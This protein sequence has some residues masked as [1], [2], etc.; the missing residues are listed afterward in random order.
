MENKV[1]V[2]DVKLSVKT[3]T[4]KNNRIS[5]EK[6]LYSSFHIS[7]NDVETSVELRTLSVN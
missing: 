1:K 7:Q 5:T 6:K 4:V 3:Y 2:L